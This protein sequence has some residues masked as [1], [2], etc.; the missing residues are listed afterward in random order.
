MAPVS[1]F[2]AGC[3]DPAACN[4]DP[5]SIPSDS[6][7]SAMVG[8]T[9]TDNETGFLSCEVTGGIAPY[10]FELLDG[11]LQPTGIEGGTGNLSIAWGGL[12]DGAYCV[13]V[14]DAAGCVEVFCDTLGVSQVGEQLATRFAI[15][16]NPARD[17]VQLALPAE[18]SVR[19]IVLR[20]ATGREVMAPTLASASAPVYVGGL[21]NGTYLVEVR[22]ADG[23]A[24]ERLVVR[25]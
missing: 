4:F 3:G 1:G 8:V 17:A 10:Q 2:D 14:T 20:D 9:A 7:C 24:I 5:C 11:A 18:W 22:H 25:H 19:S 13:E 23:V 12:P 21:A 16:P 15:Q 6:L